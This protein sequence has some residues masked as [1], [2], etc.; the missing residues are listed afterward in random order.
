V[1]N[2]L[3]S[4]WY[5]T[6][7]R[8]PG[9]D[10][11]YSVTLSGN[12]V[13]IV[14]RNWLNIT[15]EEARENLKNWF[16]DLEIVEFRCD[17][18]SSAPQKNTKSHKKEDVDALVP[19]SLTNLA[20]TTVR[21][22]KNLQ[23]D[24]VAKLYQAAVAG[25]T[26][27]TSIVIPLVNRLKA[28]ISKFGLG[29]LETPPSDKTQKDARKEKQE[30]VS[31]KSRFAFLKLILNRKDPLRM[32][33]SKVFETHD[34]AYNCGRLLAV[35]SETQ[36]KAHNYKLE[37]P[38]V[39]ERYFGRACV[40]PSSVFP[41]LLRLNRHHLEKIRKSE[42]Y[43]SHKRFIEEQL[44]TIMSLFK[45]KQGE[46]QPSFPRHLDLQAQGRF[47]IGFYQQLADDRN[48]KTGC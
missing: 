28:D 31:G 6:S 24:V 23:D 11:F 46:K 13:R 34:S 35:I 47:A 30:L 10:D 5:G 1:A 36:A 18:D 26:L 14:V 33:D 39:G 38:G 45:P 17:A 29:I 16:R 21:G 9:P 15:I 4:P 8:S 2:F 12:D 42:K 41:L 43:R 25:T 32:I 19:L 44:W 40:S 27:A 37:G 7:S 20:L 22:R 3:K 48:K